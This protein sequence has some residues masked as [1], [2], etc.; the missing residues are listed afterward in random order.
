[1]LQDAESVSALLVVV[2]GS[3]GVE[4]Q[5]VSGEEGGKRWRRGSKSSTS[6]G[7]CSGSR[8]RGGGGSCSFYFCK[9]CSRL[10]VEI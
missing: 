3:E 1:M 4:W 8:R 5:P 7:T 9:R 10:F 2:P 6:C